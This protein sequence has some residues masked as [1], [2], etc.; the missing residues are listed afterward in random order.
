MKHY[1][2]HSNIGLVG[3]LISFWQQNNFLWVWLWP[4]TSMWLIMLSQVLGDHTQIFCMI[5]LR[6]TFPAKITSCG[7]GY[8]K[9]TPIPCP[10]VFNN[11]HPDS[12]TAHA[13]LWP[14][15]FKCLAVMPRHTYIQRIYIPTKQ[16][17]Y[18]CVLLYLTP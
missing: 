1:R 16:N 9:T 10:H 15:W 3:P 14:F 12:W 18:L 6:L 7:C 17:I 4:N 8:G 5:G 2:S 11:A 13:K